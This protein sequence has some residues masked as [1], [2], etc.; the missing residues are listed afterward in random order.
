MKYL[1][2][3]IL[4]FTFLIVSIISQFLFLIPGLFLVLFIKWDIQETYNK[5]GIAYSLRGVFPKWLSIFQTPDEKMPG[6]MTMQIMQN[7]RKD[8]GIHA[9]SYYWA[10]FRNRVSGLSW[11]AKVPAAQ[12]FEQKSGMQK[13]PGDYS[14][15]WHYELK[16]GPIKFVAGYE[17]FKMSTDAYGEILPGDYWATPT[18]TIKKV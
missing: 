13:Q 18:F 5:D 7:I 16:L 6:D 15:I 1:H 11:L 10:F 2:P 9:A 17:V 3:I 4:G 12:H 14:G 8:W